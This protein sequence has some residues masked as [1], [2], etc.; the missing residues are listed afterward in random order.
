M[1]PYKLNN[2]YF[3]SIKTQNQAYLLGFLYADGNNY[4]NK[5]FQLTLEVSE[6]DKEIILFMKNEL[7]TDKPL[8]IRKETP[9]GKYIKKPTI[10]L[11]IS[12]KKIS[13]DI[14]HLGV[15]PNKTFLLK[16]PTSD[17]VPDHLI[18]H[19]IRGYFDGDGCI[20]KVGIFTHK[21]NIAGNVNFL[22]ELKLI[23]KNNSI[24][25][26]LCIL[27][28]DPKVGEIYT[29]TYSENLKFYNY[30]YKDA[31]FFLKRKKDKYDAFFK[32][33]KPMRGRKKHV[34]I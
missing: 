6:I 30:I 29:A 10:G 23:L 26:K 33:K 15:I 32:M 28:S 20:S 16:F 31:I 3:E 25:L 19:F 11:I 13:D 27:K 9:T 14:E 7:E 8:K 24:Y 22:T 34:V 12:N 21:T 4:R 2:K 1:G 18:Y 17:Q 5:H